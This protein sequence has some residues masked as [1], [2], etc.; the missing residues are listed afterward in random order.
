MYPTF[1]QTHSLTLS[2]SKAQNG[3]N[4]TLSH[5]NMKGRLPHTHSLSFSHA[6]WRAHS[7]TPTQ[8]LESTTIKYL[9]HTEWKALSIIHTR[10]LSL[11]HAQCR[12]DSLTRAYSHSRMHTEWRAHSLSHNLSLT[13]RVEGRHT[14][15]FSLLPTNTQAAGCTH[16]HCPFPTYVN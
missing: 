3:G 12:V 15:P 4:L 14:Q 1:I 11:T 2:L 9:A 10:I 5:T 6:E 8:R 13:Q 7:L 16:S